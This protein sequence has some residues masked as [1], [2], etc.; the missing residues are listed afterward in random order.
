MTMQIFDSK[1]RAD[2][3]TIERLNDVE[4]TEL[5]LYPYLQKRKNI[6]RSVLVCDLRALK[7]EFIHSYK[8]CDKTEDSK[9]RLIWSL[10]RKMIT[11][12]FC[13]RNNKQI[14][15]E[16]VCIWSFWLFA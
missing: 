4:N 3:A 9:D 7:N 6:H 12:K 10:V 16:R 11:L 8:I 5:K 15:K 2:I 1:R 13:E 14:I